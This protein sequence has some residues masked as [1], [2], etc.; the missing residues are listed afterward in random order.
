MRQCLFAVFFLFVVLAPVPGL[1]AGAGFVVVDGKTLKT[2]DGQPFLIRGISLGNWLMPEGYMF[3]F[4]VAKSPRQISDALARLVGTQGALSFWQAFR[5]RYVTAEDIAFIASLGFNVVRVPLHYRLFMREGEAPEDPPTFAGEGWQLLDRLI[6]WAKAA[7][8][9]VV[10]DLHAAPGGQTGINHDDGSGYPLLFYVA[11]HQRATIALWR[12]LAERYAEEP[13]V[14]GFDLLNEPI[15]PYH[16][17][18]LLNPRLEPFYQRIVAAIRAVDRQH[19]VFLAGGQWSSEFRLFGPPFDSQA[20]YTYHQFWSTPRRA[21]IAKYIDFAN[22]Y[23]VPVWLGETGEASDEWNRAFRTLHEQEG[24][25][26]A[27]WAYKN[28]DTPSSVVSIRRP[29]GW[30]RVVAAVDGVGAGGAAAGGGEGD[31][32]MVLAEYLENLALAACTLNRGYIASLGLTVA[33]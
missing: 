18:V 11:R 33:P 25:G 13:T 21:A 27:F 4:K 29:A 5:E 20:V 32:A 28:L 6:G 15:A 30:E 26:W 10:L 8:V 7:G 9:R 2:P 23:Q 19:I 17:T 12:A 1:A 3:K 31:V 22:R 14:L 16:D 24:I